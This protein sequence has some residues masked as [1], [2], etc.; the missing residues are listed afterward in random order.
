ME[1]TQL[2]N[3]LNILIVSLSIYLMISQFFILTTIKGSSMFPTIDEESYYI[4]DKISKNHIR[5]DIIAFKSPYDNGRYLCKRIIASQGDT[6]EIID[7][8]T[9]LNGELLDE[10]YASDYYYEQNI[11]YVLNEDEFFVMGDNRLNSLDSREFGPIKKTSVYGEIILLSNWL[12][13]FSF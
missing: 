4:I 6:I 7:E 5:G 2:E 13:I 10:P 3:K 8:K 1:N 12:T 11:S 9:Y